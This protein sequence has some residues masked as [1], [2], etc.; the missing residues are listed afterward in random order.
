MYVTHGNDDKNKLLILEKKMNQLLQF[1]NQYQWWILYM[2][3]LSSLIGKR[4]N[5]V[6]YDNQ[7]HESRL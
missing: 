7:V 3:C 6:Y 2:G 1:M 5:F 4:D